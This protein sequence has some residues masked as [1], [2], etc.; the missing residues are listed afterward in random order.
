M[1]A[2]RRQSIR[3]H[4]KRPYIAA[5]HLVVNREAGI[6]ASMHPGFGAA[7]GHSMNHSANPNTDF[8]EFGLGYAICD[9]AAGEDFVM[10]P[11]SGRLP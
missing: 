7:Q 3:R 10:A 2:S 8:T 5:N 4:P 9:I 1:L 6:C 11:A